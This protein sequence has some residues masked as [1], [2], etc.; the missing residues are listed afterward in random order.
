MLV[1]V[2]GLVFLADLVTKTLVRSRLE[3]YQSWPSADWPVHITRITNSGAAFG[4]LQNENVLLIFT[5]LIG[6]AAILFY[7][8]YPP[9]EHPLLRVALGMQLGG[10]L[11]NLVD[12]L[13]YGEVTDFISFPHWPTFNVADSC[14]TVGV[15]VL[16]TFLLLRDG[17]RETRAESGEPEDHR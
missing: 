3:M 4:I 7:L 15:I 13:R 16:A 9:F 8:F 17:G 1:G 6:L 11:G 12:R 14:I 2:A 5:S 10:A